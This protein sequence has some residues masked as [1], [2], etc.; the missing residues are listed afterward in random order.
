M[1]AVTIPGDLWESL[2]P[3]KD[4]ADHGC[5]LHNNAPLS[6]RGQI[7]AQL[8]AACVMAGGQLAFAQ[9]GATVGDAVRLA[10][11]LLKELGE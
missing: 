1:N 4:P 2:M 8:L 9:P 11:L 6:K 7:A 5:V 3:G 10:D